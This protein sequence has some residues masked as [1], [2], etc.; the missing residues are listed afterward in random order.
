MA[1][2]YLQAPFPGGHYARRRQPPEPER[3]NRNAAALRIRR[4]FY[5]RGQRLEEVV[6]H[7]MAQGL[8]RQWIEDVI[9]YRTLLSLQPRNVGYGD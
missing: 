2:Q 8:E 6:T 1:G 7:W 4:D 3:F 5:D 9:F